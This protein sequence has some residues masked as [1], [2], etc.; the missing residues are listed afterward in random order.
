MIRSIVRRPLFSAAAAAAVLGGSGAAYV[1]GTPTTA[2]HVTEAAYLG[3]LPLSPQVQ[4]E[5]S[6]QAAADAGDETFE[7]ASS[8]R[9]EQQQATTEAQRQAAE[10]ERLAAEAAA[11]AEAARVAAREQAA[12]D[13]QRDPRG[14][15]QLMLADYGW[16]GDQFGCLER[17]WTKESNWRWNA[18]NPRSSAYGIPQAL[19]GSKMSSAGGDWK[20]NPVTQISWGL[21]YIDARY[22]TPCAAWSHSQSNN[23]Y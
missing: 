7:D 16:G 23:W 10:V 6:I 11:A 17:L 8:A 19:P 18:D 21:G 12:R 5:A 13:A 22:G 2:P 20:T 3:P 4:V 14:A 9:I 15:A 1:S